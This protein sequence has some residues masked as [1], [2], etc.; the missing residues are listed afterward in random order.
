MDM[1]GQMPDDVTFTSR[2][3]RGRLNRLSHTQGFDTPNARDICTAADMAG[4]HDTLV[5]ALQLVSDDAEQFEVLTHRAVKA[6]RAALI[7][8]ATVQ[9]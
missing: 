8:A 7:A 5:A 3:L 6:I 2:A 1:S 4:V 9:R